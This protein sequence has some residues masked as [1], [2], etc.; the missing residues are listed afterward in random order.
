MKS[1]NA[2][3]LLS[4][5]IGDVVLTQDRVQELF[6]MYSARQTNYKRQT[7]DTGT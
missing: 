3:L 1:P 6:M 7:A 5:R 4:R 2:Q